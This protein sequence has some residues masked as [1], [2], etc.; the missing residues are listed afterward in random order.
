MTQHHR[1]SDR[2]AVKDNGVHNARRPAGR[3]KSNATSF[4]KGRKKTGGRKAGTPN[5]TTRILREVV[6]AAAEA[7][8]NELRGN[9][10]VGYMTWFALNYPPSFVPLYIKAM[11]S[12][13]NMKR[14][15]RSGM[16]FFTLS[17]KSVNT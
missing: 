5:K 6:L 9:G 1:L 10:D 12:S 7:A 13:L 15:C 11:H 2:P 14:S 4:K 8:G 17:R 16:W 3:P